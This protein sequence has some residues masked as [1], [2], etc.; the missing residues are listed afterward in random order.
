[1]QQLYNEKLKNK[2]L[3]DEILKL[4][5]ISKNQLNELN[6]LRNKFI[7]NPISVC[8]NIFSH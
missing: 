4:K 8:S 7:M 3:E 2:K 6:I 5:N 1:M